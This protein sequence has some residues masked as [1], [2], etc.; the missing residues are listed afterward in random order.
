LFGDGAGRPYTLLGFELNGLWL[1]S[2]ELNGRL[3]TDDTR[4]LADAEPVVFVPFAQIAGVLVP[5]VVAAAPPPGAPQSPATAQPEP[6]A[7]D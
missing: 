6:P 1:Q 7:G 2:D 3:L 4:D 5:T